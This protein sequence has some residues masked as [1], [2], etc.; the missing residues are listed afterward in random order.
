MPLRKPG[1][2]GRRR[3]LALGGG[4]YVLWGADVGVRMA[5]WPRGTDWRLDLAPG[6][7]ALIGADGVVIEAP[8]TTL[9]LDAGRYV[10]VGADGY[11]IEAHGMTLALEAGRYVVTP[12]LWVA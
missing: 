5:L 3:T 2:P 7:Y 8:G 11:V 6:V 10:L 1:K 9:L 12:T 4:G